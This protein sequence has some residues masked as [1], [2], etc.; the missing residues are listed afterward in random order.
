VLNALV[1]TSVDAH[2][3]VH[4]LRRPRTAWLLVGIAL[5]AVGVYVSVPTDVLHGGRTLHS[6]EELLR[7]DLF[8]L[9]LCVSQF[10]KDHGRSPEYLDQLVTAGYTRK[11][12]TDPFTR[13]PST[14]HV[15]RDHTGGIIQVRSGS[16]S[17]SSL[18]SR[19]S[20]W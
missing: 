20:E 2:D 15:E 12:P 19:Y 13:S 11:L 5:L 7:E 6:K 16:D 17:I 8:A 1:P 18:K 14:W 10:R 3:V 4:T 9:R